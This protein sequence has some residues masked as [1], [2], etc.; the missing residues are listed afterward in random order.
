MTNKLTSAQEISKSQAALL[1]RAIHSVRIG[2]AA[3]ALLEE[4]TEV[5]VPVNLLSLPRMVLDQ[6]YRGVADP[7]SWVCLT[8]GFDYA[9]LMVI[10]IGS[11]TLVFEGTGQIGGWAVTGRI[12]VGADVEAKAASLT[13]LWQPSA[14]LHPKVRENLE[15]EGK[16]AACRP[17]DNSDLQ[18]VFSNVVLTSAS[19]TTGK[20]VRTVLTRSEYVRDVGRCSP[21]QFQ[22]FLAA[23]STA[24]MDAGLNLTSITRKRR[25][26]EYNPVATCI[27]P[28]S[29]GPVDRAR[30][31]GRDNPFVDEHDAAGA[32]EVAIA[33]ELSNQAKS[34]RYSASTKDLLRR[35][36]AAEA[37]N[38]MI[39]QGA[40][41]PSDVS[42]FR[43]RLDK[44][45]KDF[46]SDVGSEPDTGDAFSAFV[47]AA[48][49]KDK[50]KLEQHAMGLD[51][52]YPS[53]TMEQ[54]LNEYGMP[55]VNWVAADAGRKQ[56]LFQKSAR[57]TSTTPLEY[58]KT[59]MDAFSVVSPV[60]VVSLSTPTRDQGA[61]AS[62][63]ASELGDTLPASGLTESS[64]LFDYPDF[65]QAFAAV[66]SNTKALEWRDALFAMAHTGVLGKAFRNNTDKA[67]RVLYLPF[68]MAQK[69]SLGFWE[70][71]TKEHVLL[72]L[73]NALRAVNNGQNPSLSTEEISPQAAYSRMSSVEIKRGPVQLLT[74][75]VVVGSH[76]ALE[77]AFEVAT[78]LVNWVKA[79]SNLHI[80]DLFS[81][82]PH[83][84]AEEVCAGGSSSV[85]T[86]TVRIACQADPRW[87][88]VLAPYEVLS[89]N[90]RRAARAT[91][92]RVY[93]PSLKAATLD[94]FTVGMGYENRYSNEEIYVAHVERLMAADKHPEATT[95]KQAP[96]GTAT[97]ALFDTDVYD[98]AA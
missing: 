30:K 96:I 23:L 33:K 68:Q 4:G 39:K 70:S 81:A 18:Q 28:K 8:P 77:T 9:P 27:P 7:L 42:S 97:P 38:A 48:S 13:A 71:Y 73:F 60:S 63:G 64:N 61:G 80:R 25:C 76:D 93:Q 24:A 35:R 11:E 66:A 37:T 98:E 87:N 40:R 16:E 84:G 88:R 75:T 90:E 53:E 67:A 29:R 2:L 10:P 65:C 57:A 32:V 85:F 54:W 72:P 1:E 55:F 19:A 83:L 95:Y 59:A 86:T 74:P 45:F 49:T 26:Q 46:Q 79:N 47:D 50:K 21:T 20:M 22:G 15:A 41:R 62:D 44:G 5:E 78:G 58:A 31:A 92:A 56:W 94:L 51:V 43:N 52:S 82:A 17:A 89:T 12:E 69:D 36:I 91:I 6:S 3:E 14:H 34:A